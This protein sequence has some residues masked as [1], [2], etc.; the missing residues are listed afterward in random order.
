LSE[1]LVKRLSWRCGWGRK[2]QRAPASQ[3]RAAGTLLNSLAWLAGVTMRGSC[4]FK[5]ASHS[6]MLNG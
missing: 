6:V 2:K 3:H 4:M 1:E 5:F